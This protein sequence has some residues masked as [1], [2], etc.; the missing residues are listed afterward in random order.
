MNEFNAIELSHNAL[1]LFNEQL[2]YDTYQIILKDGNY[3]FRNEDEDLELLGE[4]GFATVYL[5]RSDNKVLKKLHDEY[6]ANPGIRSRFK[7]EYEITESLQDVPGV[8]RLYD[9]DNNKM[10]YEMEKGDFTLFK[11]VIDNKLSSDEKVRISFQVMRIMAT[12]H[13]RNIIHRDLSPSNI[14]F[15]N[16]VLKIADFGLGKNIEEIH[17]HKTLHTN[18]FG[19]FYYCSPEQ[20]YALKDGDK[21]S[22]VFSL[23]KVINFIFTGNPD[24]E[25]H[26]F[27]QVINK[28]TSQN[29]DDRYESAV[30]MLRDSDKL[31]DIIKK[32]NLKEEARQDIL[33]GELTTVVQ[34]F[35]H[36]LDGERLCSQIVMNPKFKMVLLNYMKLND[37]NENYVITAVEENFRDSCPTFESYD[38]I[39][40]LAN[41]ILLDQFSFLTKE[42]AARILSHIAFSVNRFSAQRMVERL[43]DR[44]VE[45]LIENVLQR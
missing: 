23:G 7:R 33:N 6:I 13:D 2:Q 12:I 45:P 21:K 17:S 30:E 11:Y 37:N 19:Q 26:E 22:D 16:G 38:P 44:G 42:K 9:F 36:N 1:N 18:A 8:I 20:L 24:N 27:G 28:A 29:R 40:S 35:I 14:L 32:S 31:Y 3:I 25:R 39:A 34:Q 5:R 43:I 10:L 15:V 4:G 41:T